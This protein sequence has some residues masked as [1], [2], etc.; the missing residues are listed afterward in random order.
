MEARL[1]LE[2]LLK[3]DPI[4]DR[5]TSVVIP[6]FN[7]SENTGEVVRGVAAALEPLG[8]GYEVIVVND[9]SSD[10][11]GAVAEQLAS[12]NR[13]VRTVSHAS[14]LGYGAALQTGFRHAKYPL[15]LQL[16]AD[17][18]FDPCDVLKMY[19]EIDL[20]DVV[21]GYRERLPENAASFR[22]WFYRFVLRMVFAVGVR[23]VDCGFRL[24]RRTALRRIPIQSS[25]RFANAEL[26]AKATFMNLLIGEVP[27][28]TRS[29]TTIRAEH[30]LGNDRSV[31]REAAHLFRHPQFRTSNTTSDANEAAVQRG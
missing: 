29:G 17:N 26:L 10:G 11:T 28:Q 24:F 19:K 12:E 23:D 7:Q 9:G 25:G 8:R 20:V 21:C 1:E 18:Q 5:G 3:R 6:A 15:V 14:H 16:D 13:R 4:S 30:D 22:Y 31:L 27:V 2:K